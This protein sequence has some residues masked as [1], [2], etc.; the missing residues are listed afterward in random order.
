M[1]MRK[2]VLICLLI[3]S[4]LGSILILSKAIDLNP[5]EPDYTI[6]NPAVYS[7]GG[8]YYCENFGE[9]SYK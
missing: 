3:L 4:V 8:I 6:D 1:K 7:A 5:H 2:R 9:Y